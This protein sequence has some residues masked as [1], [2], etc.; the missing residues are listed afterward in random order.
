M[1]RQGS[2]RAFVAR[3]EQYRVAHQS[4]A[5]GNA[6]PELLHIA[7]AATKD[8]PQEGIRAVVMD[9]RKQF[10]REQSV[11]ADLLGEGLSRAHDPTV[12]NDMLM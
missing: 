8:V 9:T 2:A 4:R 5:I 10:M 6:V 3:L 12:S 7:R 1:K 11:L